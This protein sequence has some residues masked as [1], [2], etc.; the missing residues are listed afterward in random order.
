MT[1]VGLKTICYSDLAALLETFTD[2]HTDVD[3]YHRQLASSMLATLRTPGAFGREYYPADLWGGA[4][5]GERDVHPLAIRLT[6]LMHDYAEAEKELRR[7]RDEAQQ[8][9][10]PV[11]SYRFGCVTKAPWHWE[12]DHPGVDWHTW[13]MANV[14]RTLENVA[15]YDDF[16]HYWRQ[17]PGRPESPVSSSTYYLMALPAP[18]AHK[19]I[20]RREGGGWLI[21]RDDLLVDIDA[22]DAAVASGVV[23]ADWLV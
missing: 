13:H 17:G 6:E 12:Q 1:T 8:L 16:V 19:A 4:D 9:L 15:A 11:Y 10:A 18:L 5:P 7:L 2:G 3:G 20:V 21:L 23:P 14:V 22:W